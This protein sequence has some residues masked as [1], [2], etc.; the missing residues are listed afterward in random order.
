[1]MLA[2]R[3][4]RVLLAQRDLHLVLVLAAVDL[5]L[6][7]TGITTGAGTELNPLY[8]PFTVSF[9]LM[10]LGAGVYLA[11]LAGASVVVQGDLRR[12]LVPVV[13]G[14]HVAGTLSWLGMWGV[15]TTWW[16]NSLAGITGA[17]LVHRWVAGR[18]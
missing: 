3:H 10:L 18:D 2:R 9:P 12:V 1:M 5:A 8:R 17:V 7:I 15:P 13:A 11:V 16:W 6:T 14:M 4:P